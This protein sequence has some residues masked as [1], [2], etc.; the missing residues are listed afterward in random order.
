MAWSDDGDREALV[1]I[2][3]HKQV[4]AGDLVARVL[5]V[6]IY[7]RCSLVDDVAGRRLGVCRSAADIHKLL[8]LAL[9]EA[10]VAL[11]LFWYEANEIAHAVEAHSLELLGHICLVVDVGHDGLYVG[12]NLL[13]IG[14]AVDKVELEA[15]VGCKLS[16]NGT[17]DGAGTTDKEYFHVLL[18]CYSVFFR[19][20]SLQRYKIYLK[21]VC[22]DTKVCII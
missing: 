2:V 7:E 15:A 11:Q 14:A 19:D 3:A 12:R 9:E 21:G 20:L 6:R 13:G 18:M 4:L 5:P 10:I 22:F 17:A 1:A 16:G 8:G